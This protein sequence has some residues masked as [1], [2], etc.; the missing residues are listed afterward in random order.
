MN[1][2]ENKLQS[3]LSV[4]LFS[5]VVWLGEL[6]GGG[7]LVLQK[8]FVPALGAG[9]GVVAGTGGIAAGVIG[10]L[11]VALQVLAGIDLVKIG[12]SFIGVLLAAQFFISLFI[13]CLF[14]ALVLSSPKGTYTLSDCLIAAGVAFLE[15]I[16]FVGGFTFWGAFSVYL[17]RREFSGLVGKLS[18][19]AVAGGKGGGFLSKILKKKG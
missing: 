17:K 13:L 4:I 11:A 10:A 19:A 18:P 14:Y 8:L 5:G 15:S 1:V 6:L 12:G 7:V 2:I 3:S 9:A 16:P